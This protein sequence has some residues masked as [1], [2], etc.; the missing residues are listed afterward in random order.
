MWTFEQEWPLYEAGPLA[1]TPDFDFELDTETEFKVLKDDFDPCSI[2]IILPVM[3]PI[4]FEFVR[5]FFFF[6]VQCVAIFLSSALF[7]PF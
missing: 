5:F 7:F 4:T 3:P 1:E 6:C 2:P